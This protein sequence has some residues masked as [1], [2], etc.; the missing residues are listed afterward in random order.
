MFL[1][2][3]VHSEKK[4][5]RPSLLSVA[6]SPG[7]RVLPRCEWLVPFSVPF[8]PVRHSVFLWSAPGLLRTL[9]GG[10]KSPGPLLCTAAVCPTPPPGCDA[11]VQQSWFSDARVLL[12]CG[13]Q[14]PSRQVSEFCE[15]TS[16]QTCS[17]PSPGLHY[18]GLHPGRSCPSP[19]APLSSCLR[20]DCGV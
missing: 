18:T 5:Q 19:H 20:T 6:A 9:A 11:N 12:G 4:K 14:N 7:F 13:R 3:I 2:E 16:A 17:G 10:S 15:R 1:S 8:V